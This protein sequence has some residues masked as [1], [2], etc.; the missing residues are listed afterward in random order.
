MHPPISLRQPLLISADLATHGLDI[1]GRLRA[2]SPS[3]SVIISLKIHRSKAHKV[4][5][6]TEM[7]NLIKQRCVETPKQLAFDRVSEA[8]EIDFSG[9]P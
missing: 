5:M 2:I 1:A 6:G 4:L 8:E 3:T 7:V 9:R